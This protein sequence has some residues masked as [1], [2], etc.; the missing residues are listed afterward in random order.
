MEIS[1]SEI[2][3]QDICGNFMKW[4]LKENSHEDEGICGLNSYLK[5]VLSIE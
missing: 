2:E 4:K 3:E 5:Y 1:F